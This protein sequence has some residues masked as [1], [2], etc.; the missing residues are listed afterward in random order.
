M[1]VSQLKRDTKGRNVQLQH[2]VREDDDDDAFIA[3][4][5]ARSFK[6]WDGHTSF[7]RVIWCYLDAFDGQRVASPRPA[8]NGGCFVF[9]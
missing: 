3:S 5:E 6:A 8:S 4:F 7:L 1:R 9:K 2:K